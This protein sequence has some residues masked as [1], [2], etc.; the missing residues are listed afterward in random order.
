[1]KNLISLVLI[2][3]LL[4]GCVH[5]RDIMQGNI[6]KQEDVARLHTGM[7]EGQV[8][9]VMG[10]PVLVN[11]F[12]PNQLNYVYT[13]EPG[14]QKMTEKRLIIIFKGGRVKEI[15]QG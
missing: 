11:V 3:F 10:D 9:E 5:K 2:S 1:M 4:S 8:R 7:T 14:H 12:T 15:Q 13:F 6:I